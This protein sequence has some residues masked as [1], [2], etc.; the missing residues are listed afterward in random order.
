MNELGIIK[1]VIVHPPPLEKGEGFRSVLW[2]MIS[3]T[4]GAELLQNYEFDV[5]DINK[6][7]SPET[8]RMQALFF[9]QRSGLWLSGFL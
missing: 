8:A 7:S 2:A 6:Q 1:T 9:R 3:L 4:G 5:F